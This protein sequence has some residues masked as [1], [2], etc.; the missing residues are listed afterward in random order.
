MGKMKKIMPKKKT[1]QKIINKQTAVGLD[2]FCKN[3]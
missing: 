1:K 2:Q 3:N